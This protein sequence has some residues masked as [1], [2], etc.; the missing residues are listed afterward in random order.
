MTVHAKTNTFS[1]FFSH[2]F[3]WDLLSNSVT[4]VEHFR[5]RVD[6]MSH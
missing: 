2:S 6:V 1:E 4:Q 5:S 3:T